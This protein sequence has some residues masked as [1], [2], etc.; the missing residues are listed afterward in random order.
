MKIGIDCR[1]IY[2][3]KGK[4][5]KIGRYVYCLLQGLLKMDRQNQYVLF[6]DRRIP[7]DYA[8]TFQTKNVK[9]S[10]FPFSRYRKFLPYAYSQ[11]IVAGFLAKERLDVFHA[12]AGTAPLIY[13]G[14]TIL[15]LYKLESKKLEKF[16]QKKIARKA[17]KIIMSSESL[18][19]RLIKTY[20]IPNKRII[21]MEESGLF[22]GPKRK[23]Y[24]QKILA[25]YKN[26][27]SSTF[28]EK[29]S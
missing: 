17:K 16:P 7:K 29:A 6:F 15:N 12:T 11:F 5:S 2:Q 24:I 13:R 3:P 25:L 10:Y 18:K 19:N 26:V 21:V 4:K 28:R 20:Q 9:I 27:R 8:E 1:I 14:P 23:D 22:N